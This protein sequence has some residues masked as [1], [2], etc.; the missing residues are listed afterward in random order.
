[1]GLNLNNTLHSNTISEVLPTYVGL[2]PLGYNDMAA[3]TSVLPTY[4]GL[5]PTRRK[6]ANYRPLVLPTYVGLNLNSSCDGGSA[7]T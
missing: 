7:A 6:K 4:V 5:N 3:R 1:M 2:N